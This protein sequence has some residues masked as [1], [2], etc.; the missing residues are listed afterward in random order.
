MVHL[1]AIQVFQVGQ[2]SKAGRAVSGWLAG[3][4][5]SSELVGMRRRR[6]EVSQKE[7]CVCM[8]GFGGLGCF[9]MET[10]MA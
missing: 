4:A 3:M 10:V 8:P 2:F 5:R 9:F 6:F 1:G 7:I